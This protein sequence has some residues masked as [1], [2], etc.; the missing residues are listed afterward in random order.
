MRGADLLLAVLATS[1][2]FA[3]MPGPALLS[4]A[5]QTVARGRRAGV[6]AV[7][8]LSLGGM[9]QAVAATLGL[10]AILELVPEAYLAVKLLGAGYLISLGIQMIRGSGGASDT[11]PARV[12]R[13]AFLESVAV[14]VLNPKTALFF[15][16]R[17][18]QFTSLEASLPIWAQLLRLGTIVNAMCAL[19]DLLCVLFAGQVVSAVRQR[20]EAERIGRWL[21]GTI[22]GGL[23]VKLALARA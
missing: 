23:G 1:F 7:A 15:L 22:L 5:A 14:E 6:L 8:G 9:I 10:S 4:T 21:G 20:R 19:A 16:A 3:V 17:L 12:P 13:R 18:P 11:A 2:L